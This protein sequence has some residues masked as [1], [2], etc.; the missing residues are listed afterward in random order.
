[1]NIKKTV[2]IRPYTD[3]FVRYL[4]G[5]EK[6]SDLLLSFINAV[7]KDLDLPEIKS[8]TIRNPYNLREIARDKETV[9]D[10]KASDAA[11]RINKIY[12]GKQI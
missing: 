12:K 6:N 9:L 1:M 8:V 3:I 11:G 10:I 4:L 2:N 5:D 7:N